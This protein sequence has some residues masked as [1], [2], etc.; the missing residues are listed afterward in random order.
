MPTHPLLSQ[1]A[2]RPWPLPDG[3]WR[4]YQEWNR[5]VFLHWQVD[6]GDLRP[7]VPAA[8]ELD[9]HRDRPWVSLVAFT[10]ERIRP[11]YL[12]AFPP[13]SNFDEIN[14][15]TYVKFRGKPGVHFL[16]IEGGKRTSCR[17]ARTLSDLPYRYSQMERTANRFRSKNT[18]T[19]DEL[20]ISFRIGN[21]LN[22]GSATDNWLTERYALFQDSPGVMN[23][24]D[25]H[26][27]PWPL[28]EIALEKFQLNYPRFAAL[29]GR[30]PDLAHYSPG[31]PVI[32]WGKK[33]TR[34]A[35]SAR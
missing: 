8:L 22:S 33:V 4:Y 20:D 3:P 5:A 23:A 1:T 10:M 17:V 15:R 19:G 27:A 30:A 24:F 18:K 7:F 25:I 13:V 26:H 34:D 16:S 2:H 29:I 11:R 32:A 28:Q 14:L 9:R 31:V 12:P 6:E 35:P 21:A